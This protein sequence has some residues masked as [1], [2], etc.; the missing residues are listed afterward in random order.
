MWKLILFGVTA[1]GTY[2]LITEGDTMGTIEICII[3]VLIVLHVYKYI[4]PI[5]RHFNTRSKRNRFLQFYQ[6]LSK[7]EKDT[8][9]RLWDWDKELIQN[10]LSGKKG[11]KGDQYYED[12]LWRIYNVITIDYD[13]LRKNLKQEVKKENANS[14]IRAKAAK[15]L[16]EKN[17][18]NAELARQNKKYAENKRKQFLTKEYGADNAK[19]ILQHKVWQ[20]MNKAMLKESRGRPVK[21]QE[22]IHKTTVKNNFFY[23]SRTTRQGNEKPTFRVDLENDSVVGW[24][25][26]E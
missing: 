23:N 1:L 22:H 20:G 8:A 5:I 12:D 11:Y 4:W 24:K 3:L 17:A 13:S 21:T 18:R 6:S 9:D 26:L 25:E 19:K 7:A 2:G 16:K 15:D 10:M 14:A